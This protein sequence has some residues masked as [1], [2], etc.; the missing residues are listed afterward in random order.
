MS[1]ESEI[2]ACERTFRRF[3]LPLLVEDHSARRDVFGRAAPFLLVVLL[4]QLAGAVRLDWPAWANVLAVI[5]AVMIIFAAYVGLNLLRRRRWSTLPQDVGLP[6]LT[7]FVLAPA[8]APAIIG[9]QWGTALSVAIGNLVILAVIR[10]VVGYG[11]AATLWWGMGRLRRDL[12]SS[13]VR[14]IRFLPLLLIFSIALFY[15]AEVWQ[16]FDHTPGISDLILAGFFAALIAVILRIRLRSES[17][18]VLDRAAAAHPE[19]AGLPPLTRPQRM[20][21]SAMVGTNQLLQVI[22]IS[23]GVGAFFFALG[24]LTI[25]EGVLQEWG[26]DGGSWQRRFTLSG[27]E[28]LISQTLLRVSVAL[29]TFTG[30]YYAIS[31]LTDALYRADFVDDMAEQMA[32]VFAHRVRYLR[33]IGAERAEGPDPVR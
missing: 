22:V 12:G 1:V 30:L 25:T 7:F 31:V 13:L 4:L 17:E 9:A 28:L 24:T 8:A 11:L 2:R 33:L 18:E 14:L 16:V 3:G 15:N 20:N 27:A 32:E 23:A 29:A 19:V 26:I 6:E 10:A 21:I 5:G